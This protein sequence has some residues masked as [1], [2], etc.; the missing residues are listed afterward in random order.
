ML[1][2]SRAIRESKPSFQ[3][4][5]QREGPGDPAPPA[6]IERL[7]RHKQARHRQQTTRE[8][9]LPSWGAIIGTCD[10]PGQLPWH[11]VPPKLLMSRALVASVTQ[12][13]P[14]SLA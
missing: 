14:F 10:R 8:P 12:Q 1:A 4:I 5:R 9:F 2:R 6:R 3:E 13:P 11:A 7:S